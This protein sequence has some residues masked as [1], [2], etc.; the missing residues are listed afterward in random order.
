MTAEIAAGT[1]VRHRTRPDMYGRVRHIIGE[2]ATVTLVR[3]RNLSVFPVA[4]LDAI[5]DAE[6]AAY[7]QREEADPIYREPTS[8]ENRAFLLGDAD[9]VSPAE[10]TP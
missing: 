1:A 5:S 2:R 3:R 10:A 7:F 9:V 8:D 4:A 6:L